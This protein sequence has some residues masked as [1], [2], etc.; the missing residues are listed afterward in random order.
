GAVRLVCPDCAA[1]SPALTE[2]V[3]DRYNSRLHSESGIQPLACRGCL[4]P[5]SRGLDAASDCSNRLRIEQEEAMRKQYCLHAIGVWKM[6]LLAGLACGCGTTRFSDTT[7][8]ATE[9]LLIS[10]SIDDTVSNLDF[11][12]LAGKRVYLDPQYLD[13]VTDKGYLISSL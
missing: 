9:Q 3:A 10:H 4:H 2:V 11:R 12:M 13:G 5:A 8:T 7:R 1:G 6:F